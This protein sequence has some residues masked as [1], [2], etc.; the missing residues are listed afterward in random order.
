[1]SLN[2]LADIYILN[3][4][5]TRQTGKT[6]VLIEACKKIGG[7]FVAHSY[8][9]AQI[10]KRK[11][12]DVHITTPSIMRLRG[13]NRPIIFDHYLLSLILM[14]KNNSFVVNKAT[15]QLEELLDR[16][17]KE[18]LDRIINNPQIGVRIES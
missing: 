8:A 18:L 6:T 7:I 10:L 11:Y 16:I 9:Q 13:E 12:P 1:M 5:F 3:E 2:A 4:E 17:K 14:E 15:K